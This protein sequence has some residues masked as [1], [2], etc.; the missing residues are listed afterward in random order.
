LDEVEEGFAVKSEFS[1]ASGVS[2]CWVGHGVELSACVIWSTL[3][4][5]FSLFRQ[6]WG[7]C[8]LLI[9]GSQDSHRNGYRDTM[10]RTIA[11]HGD[12]GGDWVTV[13]EL[14]SVA[15]V[16]GYSEAFGEGGFA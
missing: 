15:S 13:W 1:T 16:E 8:R 2:G 6:F 5:I 11:V 4:V 12:K 3:S 14:S 7:E 10:I 9:L